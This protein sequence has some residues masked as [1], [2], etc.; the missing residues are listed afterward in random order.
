MEETQFPTKELHVT[1]WSFTISNRNVLNDNCMKGAYLVKNMIDSI[2]LT[3]ILGYW[4][5]SDLYADY[6]DF[7][8]TIKWQQWAFIKGWNSKTCLLCL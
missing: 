3:D 6:Y 1:E 5:G 8:T 2:G 4:T 7:K